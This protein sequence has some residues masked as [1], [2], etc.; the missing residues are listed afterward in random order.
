MKYLLSAIFIIYVIFLSLFSNAEFPSAEQ[1]TS[2]LP[3][4]SERPITEDGFYSL[5]IAWNIGTGKGVTYNFNNPTTGFQPLYVFLL[6]F[7]AFLTSAFG[8]DKITFLRIAILFSGLIA[9]FLSY[10]FYQLTKILDKN[11]DRIILQLVTSLLVLFNFKLFLNLFN[12]LE[13]GLYLML[14]VISIILT[15]KI[16]EGKKNNAHLLLIGF[17]FGLTVLARNDFILIAFIIILSLLL[18]KAIRLKD[19]IIIFTVLFLTVLPWFTFVY[20]VQGSLIPTSASV[21][22]GLTNNEIYY[23][24]DQFLYS[25]FS[26]YIPFVHAGQSQSAV[27][28][29]LIIAFGAFQ[30]KYHLI[31][32]KK[33]FGLQ[34]IRIWF[35]AI[36]V[37]SIVY[38]FFASQPYFFFRYLSIHIV[39]A[40]P[41]LTLMITRYLSNKS[42]KVLSLL[43]LIVI[44]I[45]IINIGYYFHYPKQISGL[46]LRTSFICSNQ[47]TEKKIGMAQSGI[48][49]YFFDNVVNLDGKVNNDALLA[50]KSNSLYEYIVKEKIDVLI[51]WREW[52]DSLKF[53]QFKVDWEEVN[54]LKIDSRT[55]IFESTF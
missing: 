54:D 43:A 52:F 45:F 1:G 29:I 17:V 33:Y 11:L 25:A 18:L 28:Y 22:T 13:T 35:I 20:S 12:G 24:I 50:I 55:I 40:L 3:Y 27:I 14:I 38:L 21:Q 6:S 5:K 47:L 46:A 16:I 26:S 53:D 36:T 44:G 23:R 34:V 39:I 10:L 9:L 4:L 2:F 31:D 15:Q 37:I 30:Y 8:G 49:G 42:E 51:E 41:F 48:S 32:I 19:T 7:F